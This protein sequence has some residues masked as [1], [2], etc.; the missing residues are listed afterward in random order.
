MTTRDD[1]NTGNPP[2]K[3]AAR[4]HGRAVIARGLLAAVALAGLAGCESAK[5]FRPGCPNVGVLRDAGTYRVPGADGA[6]FATAV[7]NPPA[8]LCE[9]SDD[10]VTIATTFTISARATAGFDGTVPVDYFVAVTDP[11]RNVIAKQV[12]S[13]A[14]RMDGGSGAVG[15]ETEQFI[16]A[17]RT[18]DAR[19]YEVLVG[20]QLPPE[21]VETNRQVN[22]GR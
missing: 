16:P 15:E 22:Q 9:Y 3:A 5:G 1:H 4:P 11:Q 7:I 17:P 20:F 19:Y 2:R 14:I 8:A 18:V 10:G 21:Q 12:F 6:T 13:T